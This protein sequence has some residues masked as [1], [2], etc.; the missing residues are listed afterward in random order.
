MLGSEKRMIGVE[1]AISRAERKPRSLILTSAC[2]WETRAPSTRPRIFLLPE[3]VARNLVPPTPR[4]I[5]SNQGGGGAVYQTNMNI[6]SL[7]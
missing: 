5:A 3:A 6:N 4:Y 1:A 7:A 2:E